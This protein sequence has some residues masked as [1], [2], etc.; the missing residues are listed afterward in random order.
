M[1]FLADRAEAHRAGRESL[2]DLL[3]RLHL[4]DRNRRVSVLQLQQPAQRTQ[5]AILLI[6]KIGVLLERRRVV[7]RA[8]H[9]AVC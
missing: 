6:E 1:R 5:I 3:G 4:F 9:A 8:P 7:L 2:D